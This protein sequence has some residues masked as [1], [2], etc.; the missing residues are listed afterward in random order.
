[1][2]RTGRVFNPHLGRIPKAIIF[3][4]SGPLRRDFRRISRGSLRCRAMLKYWLVE[5]LSFRWC[6]Y[7]VIRWRGGASWR[8]LK[9]WFIYLFQ[10]VNS[11]FLE[12]PKFILAL[13]NFP[14]Y[15]IAWRI[16]W[17]KSQVCS[18]SVAPA[19]GQG[20]SGFQPPF[21]WD[22]KSHNFHASRAAPARFEKDFPLKPYAAAQC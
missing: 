7:R 9:K 10:V 21:G 20:R 5:H 13:P 17:Y 4:L 11:R 15:L 19:H 18:F 16:E 1:M 8:F 14:G 3:M 22:P 6:L 2:G 12:I